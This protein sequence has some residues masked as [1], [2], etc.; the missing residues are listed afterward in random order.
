MSLKN[1]IDSSSVTWQTK[2]QKPS[3]PDLR[4]LHFN[5]VYHIEYSSHGP[6]LYI[7]V[8]CADIWKRPG[9]AEPVGGY[10]RFQY[11]V[12][13]YRGGLE[14]KGQPD[15]ISLFSGDAFNPSL[16]SSVTKGKHMLDILNNL[17]T[18]MACIGVS[19]YVFESLCL[20]DL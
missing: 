10:P 13:Q 12:N 8:F 2:R 3:P 7:W 9:S 15:L 4:F 11:L 5:D 17:P 16:E 18:A 20:L 19:C 14:Y 1:T 6:G